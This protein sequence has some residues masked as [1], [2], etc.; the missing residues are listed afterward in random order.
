MLGR[1]DGSSVAGHVVGDYNEEDHDDGHC[2]TNDM[3][4]MSSL[5]MIML[6]GRRS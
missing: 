5:I 2:K 3:I 1:E 6:I 4:T